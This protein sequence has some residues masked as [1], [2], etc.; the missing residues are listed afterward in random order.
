MA[1]LVND[2]IP[3]TMQRVNNE[4]NNNCGKLDIVSSH[5]IIVSAQQREGRG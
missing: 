1:H 3:S 5:L 2:S 4:S